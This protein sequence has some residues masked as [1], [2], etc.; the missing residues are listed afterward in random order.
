MDSACESHVA[1]W[2]YM[3]KTEMDQF[4]V[5]GFREGEWHTDQ[6]KFKPGAAVPGPVTFDRAFWL[7]LVVA[8]GHMFLYLDGR[9]VK[10]H[11]LSE[12]TTL[13][14]GAP[15]SVMV[16]E[17]AR[18][19]RHRHSAALGPRPGPGFPPP[20]PAPNPPPP[21]LAHPRAAAARGRL[22]RAQH[23]DRLGHVVGLQP[24]RRRRPRRHGRP[25]PRGPAPPRR[26]HGGRFRPE[27]RPRGPA[28]PGDH[29]GVAH[30]TPCSV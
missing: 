25:R 20:D 26:P 27:A 8:E 4:Y 16:S 19:A 1:L 24:A 13:S 23:H 10:A 12:G 2:Q 6:V 15:I 11:P 30:G 5:L 3:E 14:D 18:A 21:P 22:R 9:L 17:A 7:R 28:A 29:Q